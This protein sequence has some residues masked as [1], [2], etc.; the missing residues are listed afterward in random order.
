MKK[1]SKRMTIKEMKEKVQKKQN[2]KK[3]TAGSFGAEGELYKI[4][5]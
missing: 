3:L 1:Q 5:P 2:F 4:T